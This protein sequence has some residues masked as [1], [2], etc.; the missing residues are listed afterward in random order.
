MSDFV[1]QLEAVVQITRDVRGTLVK[2]QY[3]IG[4]IDKVCGTHLM[5]RWLGTQE[6]CSRYRRK[7]CDHSLMRFSVLR[8]LVVSSTRPRGLRYML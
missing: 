5:E 3:R 1:E 7:P 8:G 2:E 4:I 6:V